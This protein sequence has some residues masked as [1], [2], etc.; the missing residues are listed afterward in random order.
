M[1]N[2]DFVFTVLD[3]DGKEIVC[4][5][6]FTYEDEKTGKNYIVYT[7]NTLDEDGDT[8]VFASTFDPNENPPRLHPLE[9]EE[10]WE[11]AESILE[12]LQ[13]EISDEDADF[14]GDDL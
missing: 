9:T 3:E 6:L 11:Q 10:E 2:N 7:D 13:S 5:V 12:H 8:K 1:E 14:F 4:E